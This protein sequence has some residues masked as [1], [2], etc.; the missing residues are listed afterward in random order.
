MSSWLITT[1]ILMLNLRPRQREPLISVN[2]FLLFS[3]FD[4][5]S[6]FLLS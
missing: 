1:L 4:L 2:G 6:E 3:L 5:A